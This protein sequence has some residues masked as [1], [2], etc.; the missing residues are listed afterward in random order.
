MSDRATAGEGK[1]FGGLASELVGLVIAYAKQ[2]TIEPIKA[3]GRFVAF[4]VAGALMIALGGGLLTLGAVRAVQ[5]EAGP[6]VTGNLNWT[7]YV[8]GILVAGIGAGWAVSRIAKGTTP[9]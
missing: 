3:L 1:S 4:G 6:H 7:P 2:E 5:A 8:A 9:K